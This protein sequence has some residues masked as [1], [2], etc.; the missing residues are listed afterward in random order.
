M[1]DFMEIGEYLQP[2]FAEQWDWNYAS[3]VNGSLIRE[4]YG[5]DCA[6]NVTAVPTGPSE[7]ELGLHK[8]S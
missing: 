2:K 8:E 5:L 7:M 4:N 1:H 6:Q 3:V